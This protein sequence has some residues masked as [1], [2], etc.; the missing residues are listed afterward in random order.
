M[1]WGNPNRVQQRGNILDQYKMSLPSPQNALD[2]FPGEWSSRF[3]GEMGNLRAGALPLFEIPLIPWFVKEI[4][5]IEGKSVLD[6][7]PLEG[8]NAYML[9]QLGARSVLAI[10][11]NTRAYLKCLIVKELIGLTRSRFL[12]GD[13]VSFLREN[14][15]RFD[16]L[17]ASG[18]LYHMINPVELIALIAKA[19]DKVYLW[20]QYYDEPG[21]SNSASELN[22]TRKSIEE[23]GGFRHALYHAEYE[24]AVLGNGFCGGGNPDR[25]LMSRVEILDCLKHFGL[26]N[27]SVGWEN[28][29]HQNGPAFALTAMRN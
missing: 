1:R 15:E 26:A 8:G 16:V 23:Y 2:I 14:S 4:G 19:T 27:I 29:K 20:T 5:G 28:P 25:R 17:I 6:L 24:K 21:P 12:C 11:A 22:I 7:G 18:V 9:E 3:P 13:F 10:E